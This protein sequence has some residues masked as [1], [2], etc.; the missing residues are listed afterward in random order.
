V[1]TEQSLSKESQFTIASAICALA[2]GRLRL[3]PAT[4]QTELSPRALRDNPAVRVDYANDVLSIKIWRVFEG[5]VAELLPQLA[6]WLCQ[7]LQVTHQQVSG[8][9][10]EHDEDLYG[11]SQHCHSDVVVT[12]AGVD[13]DAIVRLEGACLWMCWS[14]EQ[15]AFALKALEALRRDHEELQ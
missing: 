13:A 2:P 12:V 7:V 3:R 4:K 8:E 1:S 11:D 6:T 14:D 10:E 9:S 5:H 15:R